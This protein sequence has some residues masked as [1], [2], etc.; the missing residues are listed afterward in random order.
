M[1]SD[2]FG[3][4][5]RGLNL[6]IR[7]CLPLLNH[8]KSW[9]T[10][11]SFW[12]AATRLFYLNLINSFNISLLF[13][14][15]IRRFTLFWLPKRGMHRHNPKKIVM[16]IHA[17][18]KTKMRFCVHISSGSV[19]PSH[20]PSKK[21]TI[22]ISIRIRSSWSN[23]SIWLSWP[24]NEHWHFLRMS[25]RPLPACHERRK[26][27]SIIVYWTGIDHTSCLE[28]EPGKGWLA[29]ASAGQCN[30]AMGGRVNSNND[31]IYHVTLVP[32]GERSS[33]RRVS[34][35]ILS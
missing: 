24:S 14:S 11:C 4:T 18:K 10:G 26:E 35:E 30:D 6:L 28:P 32:N 17:G 34:S 25:I 22:S 16:C 8:M 21:R 20:H 9:A 7:T 2:W 1:W 33:Q 23:H 13:L 19:Q 29:R 31:V 15:L 27:V 5:K 12:S 3:K